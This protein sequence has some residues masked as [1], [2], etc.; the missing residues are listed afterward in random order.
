MV[1]SFDPRVYIRNQIGYTKYMNRVDVSTVSVNDDRGDRVYLPLYLPGE[2]RTGD[3]PVMP[4]IEM[5]L[6]SSPAATMD[7]GGGVKDQEAYLDFNIYYT[8]TAHITPSEFGKTVADEIED[9]I[10]TDRS[11]VASTYFVEVVNSG[12][13]IIEAEEGKQVIF[14]RVLEIK[15]K[16]YS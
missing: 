13:E 3:M 4:F 5:V 9:K 16:N 10:L 6:V 12:R 8:N 2:V 7:I 1:S 15:C 14:H 11:S